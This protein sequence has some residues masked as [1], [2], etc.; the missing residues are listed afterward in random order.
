MKP[1]QKTATIIMLTV[2]AA[3]LTW[4]I[5]WKCGVPSIGG[6]ERV[7]N[8]TPFRGNTGWEMQFNCLLFVPLGF[9]V[10][11]AM[12]KW[13][14]AKQILTI[15]AASF[16]LEALQ[17]AFAIGRSDITDLLMNTLGG[18]IGICGFGLIKKLCGK[19]AGTITLI[20]GG[21]MIAFVLYCGVCFIALGY[22]PIGRVKF[23]L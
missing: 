9:Y 23:R 8:F 6:T 12:E 3:F 5:L 1:K 16:L 2:Y 11:A 20:L 15:F 10:A 7:V 21:L 22:L 19:R 4:A 14:V 13:G 17:F 18:A